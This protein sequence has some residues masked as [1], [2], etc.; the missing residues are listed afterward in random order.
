MRCTARLKISGLDFNP[1]GN[2]LKRYCPYGVENADN[3]WLSVEMDM[4]LKAPEMSVLEYN[5]L[6]LNF[7]IWCFML[8]ILW[9]EL[10]KIWFKCESIMKV[11]RKITFGLSTFEYC[12]SWNFRGG[13]IYFREFRES[14]FAKF[15]TLVHVHLWKEH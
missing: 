7:E 3:R 9:K 8:G 6:F 15:S 1:V 12:T 14:I 5:T 2:F 10:D 4:E 11:K 13:L